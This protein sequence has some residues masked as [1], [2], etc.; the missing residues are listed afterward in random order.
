M[1]LPVLAKRATARLGR[2]DIAE[3]DRALD[4]VSVAPRSSDCANSDDAES[5]PEVAA[6]G[7]ALGPLSINPRMS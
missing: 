3:F 6:S 4:D 5:Q 7:A 1:S 2:R